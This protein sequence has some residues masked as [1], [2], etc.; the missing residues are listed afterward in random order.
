MVSDRVT[1]PHPVCQKFRLNPVCV[2][3]LCVYLCVC[4]LVLTLCQVA[5]RQSVGDVWKLAAVVAV[6]QWADIHVAPFLQLLQ[7]AA[8]LLAL[9]VR[10]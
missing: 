10:V 7:P 6:L 2:H 4:V 8:L 5:L 9:T 1:M 3:I